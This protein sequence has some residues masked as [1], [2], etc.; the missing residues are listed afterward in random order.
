M[1]RLLKISTV[2]LAISSCIASVS[3]AQSGSRSYSDTGASTFTEIIGQLEPSDSFEQ[4]S[5][6]EPTAVSNTEFQDAQF[7]GAD[8]FQ[9]TSQ[10]RPAT[11]WRTTEAGQLWTDSPD[12][13]SSN[14]I[15][16]GMRLQFG[17][18]YLYFSR[19][20]AADNF[21]AANDAGETFSL[22]DIDPGDDTTLRYRFLIATEGGT[23][24][25]FV[26][27]DFDDFSG[28]IQLTGEGITPIFFDAVPAEPADSY[29]A[30][31]RSQ[32]ENYELNVWGRRSERVRLGYGLRYINLDENFDVAFN[33]DPSSTGTTTTT[34][35]GSSDQAGFFSRT[36]NEIFGG[37]LMVQLYHPIVPGVYVTGGAN[38]GYGN[39]HI[40]VD[41]DTA[42]ID[43]QD[44]GNTG[45]G[46]FSFYGGVS[47]RVTDGWT[48][49][50]GYEGL[51]L[52]SVALAPDQS[53]AADFAQGVSEFQTGALYFSGA[54]IGTVLAF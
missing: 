53:A 12:G 30:S 2:F 31:Y 25:E 17:V 32:L 39:N 41:S 23:G 10:P 52:T 50:A 28:S 45:T 36:N 47:M 35:T 27:Y 13:G 20:T 16:G 24:F 5:A 34:T 44:E 54:Y 14:W 6:V 29:D 11:D 7:Q 33:E 37:Q 3:F 48:F 22:A 43:T 49:N 8:F 9:D 18:D 15:D 4:F 1:K 46:F 38:S 26:T 19:S 42:N 21:F 40:E 51:L